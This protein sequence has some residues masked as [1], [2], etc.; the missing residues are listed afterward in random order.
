MPVTD[1][2]L[3]KRIPT[4]PWGDPKDRHIVG[5]DEYVTTGGY[6]ALRKALS[7]K[8]EAVVDLIKESQ[9]RGRGGAGFPCG[10]KWT[11]LPEPDGGRRYLAVNSD[12]AEQFTGHRNTV[13]AGKALLEYGPRFVV[14]KKG[15]HGAILLI[16]LAVGVLFVRLNARGS[17]VTGKAENVLTVTKLFALGIFIVYG[18]RR[19]LERDQL[20]LEPGEE[21]AHFIAEAVAR[22][23]THSDL[24]GIAGLRIE[25][26]VKAT[27]SVDGVTQFRRRGR[28]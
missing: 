23:T 21:H 14:I 19:V 26:G 20:V 9:L 6:Q 18:L 27:G 7:M 25:I 11:F 12:E 16:T 4:H 13:T 24:S 1:P 5:Y 17:E 10:L 8:P 3:V 22:L 2:V 15:E 28:C